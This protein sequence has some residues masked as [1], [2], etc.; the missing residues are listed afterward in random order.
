MKMILFAAVLALTACKKKSETPAGPS[1]AD[2]IA[3]AVGAMP[4]GPGGG[5]VQEQLK[6]IMTKRCTE[7]H[8]PADAINCYATQA[9]DMASMKKCREMLPADKQQQ[10][11]TEIRAVMMGAAGAGGGP[12]HGAPAGSAVEPAGSGAAPT[13]SAAAP[14]GSAE[15][16]K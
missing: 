7:D 14:A 8:W 16:P 3:K 2:A 15:P 5:N 12:M 1:C 11:M 4:G 10:L 6:T 13:G 9:T